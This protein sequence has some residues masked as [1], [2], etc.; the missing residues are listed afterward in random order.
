M[1]EN[2]PYVRCLIAEGDLVTET[3]QRYNDAGDPETAWKTFNGGEVPRLR[4]VGPNV[5]AKWAAAAQYA[6]E[7]GVRDGQAKALEANGAHTHQDVMGA[8]RTLN[9]HERDVERVVRYLFGENGEPCRTTGALR[10]A[11]SSSASTS[12]Q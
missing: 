1:A 11:D 5:Q 3:Y 7:R 2:E 12:G 10:Q 6:Y 8:L 9:F 4:D